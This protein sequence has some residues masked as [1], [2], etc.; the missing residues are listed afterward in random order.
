MRF[1]KEI[2]KIQKKVSCGHFVEQVAGSIWNLCYMLLSSRFEPKPLLQCDHQPPLHPLPLAQYLHGRL[3]SRRNPKTCQT[4]PCRPPLA[5]LS[6][7]SPSSFLH[8]LEHPCSTR[9]P[10][11]RSPSSPRLGIGQQ[12]RVQNVP[13]RASRR[14]DHA[15]DAPGR[16]ALD[17]YRPR[18]A[19]LS[20]RRA[21]P[22]HPLHA[23]RT[24]VPALHRRRRPR[25]K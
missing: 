5:L 13:G 6:L 12:Q 15:L 22:L 24:P 23:R 11:V 8:V 7:A 9:T 4:M 1:T 17:R 18:P 19:S 16:H 10:T 25:P 3:K 14:G 2:F 20:P 21:S